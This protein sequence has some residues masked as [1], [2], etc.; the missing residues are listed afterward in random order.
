M[1]SPRLAYFEKENIRHLLISE[2][3]EIGCVSTT[4]GSEGTEKRKENSWGEIASV[5]GSC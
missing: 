3:P 2:G 1:N 4:E 5:L